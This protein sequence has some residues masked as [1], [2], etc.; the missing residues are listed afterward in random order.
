MPV[1]IPKEIQEQLNQKLKRYLEESSTDWRLK[2]AR[3][4]G[5]FPAGEDI[6]VGWFVRP[7]GEVLMVRFLISEDEEEVVPEQRSWMRNF[8]LRYGRFPELAVFLP[9][10]PSSAQDCPRCNG[11]GCIYQIDS[12]NKSSQWPCRTCDCLGWIQ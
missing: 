10:R 3:E 7:T 9:E 6:F 5:A 2:I 4:L 1:A 8:V 12:N 11:S